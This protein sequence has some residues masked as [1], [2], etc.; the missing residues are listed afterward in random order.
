MEH[1]IVVNEKF[2]KIEKEEYENLNAG[3]VNEHIKG[4]PPEELLAFKKVRYENFFKPLMK[5]NIFQ[6]KKGEMK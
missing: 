2:I 5:H 4:L 6:L 3:V 1:F